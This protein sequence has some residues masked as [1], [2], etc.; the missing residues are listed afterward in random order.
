[1]SPRPPPPTIRLPPEEEF[2]LE[3]EVQATARSYTGII[4]EALRLRRAVLEA[5][6]IEAAGTEPGEI[7]EAVR[8]A[9]V[10]GQVRLKSAKK[11]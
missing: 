7:A 6:G 10:V 5:L 8:K 2:A 1:M 11:K 9:I 3:E 4:T